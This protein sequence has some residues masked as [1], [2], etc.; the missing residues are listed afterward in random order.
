[1]LKSLS[2]SLVALV[3]AA[4][5]WAADPT[6][7]ASAAQPSPEQAAAQVRNDLQ[8]SRADIMAK[9]LTLSAEQ[10]AKFWPLYEQYQKEQNVIIDG[11]LKAIQQY[12]DKYDQLK[13]ADA[14]AFVNALLERDAK[15]QALRVKWLTKFQSAVPPGTAARAI[16][17][18]RRLSLAGQI[19]LSSMI[20]L[21]Q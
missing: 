14:V 3:L 13:D 7:T 12:A 5:A 11:Q 4:P 8:A 6:G 1:V 17:L 10:A 20:P 19:Q 2:S 9:G 18:D 16:Q 21:V 15:M